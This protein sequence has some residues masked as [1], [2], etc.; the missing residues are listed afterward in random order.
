MPCKSISQI[1]GNSPA[2]QASCM[3]H[4]NQLALVVAMTDRILSEAHALC[5]AMASASGAGQSQQAPDLSQVAG[6]PG[7]L[8]ERKG[9]HD[10]HG[11]PTALVQAAPVLVGR[12][13]VARVRERPVHSLCAGTASAPAAQLVGY[14]LRSCAHF[15][16]PTMATAVYA[17]FPCLS[18][19]YLCIPGF[20]A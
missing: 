16:L 3:S 20:S 4:A 5:W 2:S 18:H 15:R 8:L 17:C 9:R 12:L 13:L 14:G 1:H 11:R 19:A 10:V 7:Q 6:P